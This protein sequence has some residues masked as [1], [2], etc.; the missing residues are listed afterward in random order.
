MHKNVKLHNSQ[1][2]IFQ[3]TEIYIHSLAGMPRDT[4]RPVCGGGGGARGPRGS[5]LEIHP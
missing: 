2:H 1:L 4:L 3:T 5:T